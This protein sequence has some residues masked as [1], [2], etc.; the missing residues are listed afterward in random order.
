MMKRQ[1]IW[2]VLLLAGMILGSAGAETAIPG[3]RDDSPCAAEIMRMLEEIDREGAP[4]YAP[5][6]DRIAVFDFDGTLFGERF[7][8]YFDHLLLMR[9]VLHD[10]SY[11]APAET[12]AYV[13]ALEQAE[14]ARAEA[15]K[16]DKLS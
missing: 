2:I 7:P 15:P 14:L 4:G 8:T 6:E 10:D 13:A 3:W 1:V 11:E 5:R 9:R 12:R 16:G